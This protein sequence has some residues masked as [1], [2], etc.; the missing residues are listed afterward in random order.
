MRLSFLLGLAAI[1]IGFWTGHA[2][3]QAPK[4]DE[5]PPPAE[6]DAAITAGLDWL[7]RHQNPSGGWSFIDFAQECRDDPCTGRGD[8]KADVAA[9]A[10]ALMPYLSLGGNPQFEGSHQKAVSSGLK[11]LVK[12]QNPKN[13]SLYADAGGGSRMYAHGIASMVLCDA[14]RL[15]KDPALR[16]PAQRAVRFIEDSQ[17]PDQ[18]GWRYYIAGEQPTGGDTSVYGWQL[19]A[20]TTARVAGLDVK[21]ETIEKSRTYLKLASSGKAGGLFSYEPKGP[22]SPSMTAVGLTSLQILPDEPD[23]DQLKEGADWLNRLAPGRQPRDSYLEYYVTRSLRLLPDEQRMN[24]NKALLNYLLKTQIHD[25]CA[26]GSWDAQRPAVDRW[27]Q[28]GGRLMITSLGLVNLIEC[29]QIALPKE[30]AK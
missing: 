4:A 15:S 1:G 24:W 6:V 17:H 9:T 16:D 8:A 20:L 22:P 7:T 13:G 21:P 30:P 12:Q 19:R 27:G 5:L 18:G 11:F 2:Q 28:S 29:R 26:A 10:F 14:Y 25:G 3:G 23:P